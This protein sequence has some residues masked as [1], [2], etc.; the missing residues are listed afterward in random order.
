[1]RYRGCLGCGAF[2]GRRPAAYLRSPNWQIAY[3]QAKSFTGL[4]CPSIKA[5]LTLLMPLE[6]RPAKGTKM[7][8][9]SNNAGILSLT[10]FAVLELKSLNL[11]ARETG[12][13]PATSGATGRLP[14]FSNDVSFFQKLELTPYYHGN[15]FSIA[16]C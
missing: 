5:P 6:L 9:E 4:I 12:L 16:S 8:Q 2:A 7:A 14:R 3:P 11:L 10:S 13:E 15:T 1:L